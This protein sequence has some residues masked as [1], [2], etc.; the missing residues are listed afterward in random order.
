VD[1][2]DCAQRKALER[3]GPLAFRLRPQSLEEFAGQ[4]HL[5]APGR[6]LYNALQT[7]KPFSAIFYGPPGTGK[8][9]LAGIIA[10]ATQGFFIQIDATST[11]VGE[12]RKV[13]Q[14]ARDRLKYHNQRTI[15]FID[16]IHRFN[17]AQQ[18]VLLPAVEQ[19]VVILIGATTENPYFTVNSPLLSRVRVLPF[20]PL[21]YEDL[22][23]ILRRALSDRERGLG[24][25]RI[26]VAPEA[27][28]HWLRVA[29]GDARVLLNAL[30]TAV[31]LSKPGADGVYRIGVEEAAAAVQQAPVRYD[32]EG[33]MHYDV[34]SA[35]IKSMRGSDPDAALHWL[36]RMLKAGE[37]PRFIARRI[38]I[39]AAED[40]G[41]ADPLALVVAEAAAR[42]LE[43]V[44][45]PEGRLLLAEA[46]LYIAC[47]PKS[48]SV[49]RALEEAMQ[50]IEDRD[51]GDVPPHLRDS[52]YSGAKKL[53]HG[54]GYLYPHNY[55]RHYVDQQ[56]LPDPLQG[57][58]Y[59]RPSEN[60]REKQIRAWLSSLKASRNEES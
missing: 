26:Q 21:K 5:V 20:Y 40:V 16:E 4:E 60:G 50:D 8:T 32:R 48:N 36:A 55:P 57:R 44:G 34:T 13:L 28:E 59:Y 24:K 27:E 38:V 47:A 43:Q 51:T 58:V 11:G 9:T 3:E 14:E 41:L 17:K 35:F 7:D 54:K 53:G 23:K 45:M 15:L 25:M 46:V 42:G 10:R 37:D 12:L 29:G 52:H 39:C 22:Q 18:D 30:E 49:Y 31:H 6:L 19:G 2:F 56:Y 1:L 33:D